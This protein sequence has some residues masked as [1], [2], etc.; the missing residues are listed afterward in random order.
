MLHKDTGWTECP[1]PVVS[2]LLGLG[3][4]DLEGSDVVRE[5]GADHRTTESQ[6]DRITESTGL[7]KTFEI[8]KPNL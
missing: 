4:G 3:L 6:H 5:R 2:G 1:L 7:E 8:T